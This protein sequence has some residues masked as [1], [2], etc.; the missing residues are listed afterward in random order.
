MATT[1]T[2]HNQR[3]DKHTTTN[4]RGGSK[5]MFSGDGREGL[6]SQQPA[7]QPAANQPAS[8]P[9]SWNS[10]LD[11]QGDGQWDR[12]NRFV[13]ERRA[14]GALHQKCMARQSSPGIKL[15]VKFLKAW[16]GKVAPGAKLK[17]KFLKAKR[18]RTESGP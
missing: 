14:E 7:S 13:P 18:F 10:S 4:I 6:A 17:V 9:S 2:A 1:H 5:I 12:A 11:R 8:Q 15:K 16:L 3:K